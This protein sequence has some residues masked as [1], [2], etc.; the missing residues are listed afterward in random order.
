MLFSQ[1]WSLQ[2]C[3]STN[4]MRFRMSIKISRLCNSVIVTRSIGLDLNANVNIWY[5]LSKS[6]E[7]KKNIDLDRERVALRHTSLFLL[8][9]FWPTEGNKNR[10]KHSHYLA[11]LKYRVKCTR[12]HEEKIHAP[13]KITANRALFVF[14]HAYPTEHFPLLEPQSPLIGEFFVAQKR[15]LCGYRVAKCLAGQ[16]Y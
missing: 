14:K 1:L 9:V 4:I 10:K 12:L 5:Y 8:R 6:G 2:I 15:R 11:S 7:E 3:Q 13:N 16:Y